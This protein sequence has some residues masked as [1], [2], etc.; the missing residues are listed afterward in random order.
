MLRE[1]ESPL[2][3]DYLYC[4]RD[5]LGLDDAIVDRAVF[6]LRFVLV[7]FSD[8]FLW[9]GAELNRPK[10]SSQFLDGLKGLSAG[11]WWKNLFMASCCVYI[12][13]LLEGNLGPDEGV[14]LVIGDKVQEL[15]GEVL[16]L[17]PGKATA[18]DFI[19][20]G[21]GIVSRLVG[22]PKGGGKVYRSQVFG[23]VETL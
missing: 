18:Q 3:Y 8:L 23:L 17:I 10:F 6:V 9:V 22:N 11:S 16:G 1:V 12:G 5:L 13:I 20:V 21:S 14:S 19:E 7:E 15:F 2:V 4:L